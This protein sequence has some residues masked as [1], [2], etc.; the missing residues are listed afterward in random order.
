MRPR[1]SQSEFEA[2][3]AKVSEIDW[4]RLA[5]FIDGEGSILIAR[6]KRKGYTNLQYNL[7]VIV[8]GTDLR[9]H[10]WLQDTFSGKVYL[11]KPS[12]ISFRSNKI[13]QSWRLYNTRA[14]T[15][16]ERC[17]PYFIIKR[18][19]AE[20]GLAFM[21]LKSQ[22]AQGKRVTP[23]GLQAREEFR[24][25]LRS[26]NSPDGQQADLDKRIN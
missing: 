7:E 13:C 1:T 9:L 5:A 25:Q 10:V 8:S 20:V 26:I 24:N 11:V 19:Q 16:L 22:G 12:T 2:K 3:I 21:R 6:S 17:L 14:A 18:E 15:I 23:E 4:A